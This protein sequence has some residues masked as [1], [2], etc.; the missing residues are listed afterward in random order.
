M[1][2]FLILS[3]LTL[4]L[5]RTLIASAQENEKGYCGRL[6]NKEFDV[7]FVI[8]LQG[9]GIM[10]PGHDIY[11]PLAG[12]MGKGDSS[13]FWLVVDS[14]IKDGKALMQMVNDFG[15]EDLT[16]T[17]RQLNDSTYRLTQGKGSV[18]KLPNKGK[19]IKLPNTIDFVK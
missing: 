10:V 19:W 2:H 1:K 16:V 9:K 5:W 6:Y 12:Y 7:F 18:I 14:E 8:D 4:S 15:S 11:G 13:F 17:L 3:C